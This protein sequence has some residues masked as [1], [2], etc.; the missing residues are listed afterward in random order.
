MNLTFENVKEQDL[1][2]IALL[3]DTERS[4]KTNREKMKATFEKTKNNKEYQIIVV[5]KRRNSWFC[6]CLSSPRYF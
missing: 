2:E 1:E 6:K 4:I 5:K 3:Y